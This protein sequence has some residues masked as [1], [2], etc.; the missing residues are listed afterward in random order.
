MF[1]NSDDELLNIIEN[2]GTCIICEKNTEKLEKILKN[3]IIIEEHTIDAIRDML[4]LTVAK[5]T[6][7]RYFIFKDA[8][9]FTEEAQNASLKLFEEPK[10][11]YHF[12]L[13]SS[14]P[15]ELLMTIRSRAPIYAPLALNTLE[16]P[17]EAEKEVFELAKKLLVADTVSIIDIAESL[18][19]KKETEKVSRRDFALS[20]IKTTIELAE[21]SYFKTENEV[22]TRKI[23][24]L[25][26]AY[27]NIELNGSIRLQLVANLV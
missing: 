5:A 22:F 9:K 12:I 11:N 10:E 8:E 7:P 13:Q 27:K 2:A 25:I 19:K 3:P 17:P 24:G 4:S 18:Q 20:V 23:N 1:Y 21:K 16:T 14:E 26:I 15:E 6:V